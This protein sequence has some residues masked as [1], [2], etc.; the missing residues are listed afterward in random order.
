M[1]QFP[2][3]APLAPEQLQSKCDP[4]RIEALLA[5]STEKTTK[6]P[7]GQKRAFEALEFGLNIKAK[8]YNIFVAGSPG[9]G[10][11]STTLRQIKKRARRDPAP[12][13]LCYLFNF[14]DHYRPLAAQLAQGMGTILE[15][16]LQ[17]RV[18]ALARSI[19][20]V[21]NEDLFVKRTS[22]LST[23]LQQKKSEL[24]DA[25]SSIAEKYELRMELEDEQFLVVPLRDG[26]PIESDV[27]DNL[28]MEEQEDIQQRVSSF[29]DEAAPVMAEQ[30]IHEQRLE[31]TLSTMERDAIHNLV[32]NAIDAL[33]KE[34][35]DED[36]ALMTYFLGMQD[37]IMENYKELL[38]LGAEEEE[39]LDAASLEPPPLPLQ[40]QVNTLVSHKGKGA[41]VVVEKE[42]TIPHL[43]GYIEYQESPMGLATDHTLLRGGA[44]HRANGGYLVLQ[45][46][47]L[48]RSPEVWS[49]FKR[50]LRH[51]EV[52]IQDPHADPDKPRLYGAIRPLGL[53]L[54]LK[55]ILI[56]SSESYYQL[57]S[58]DEDFDRIFKVKAEF[59][60]WIPRSEDREL[61]YCLFLQ[62]ISEEEKLL[63]PDPS[64]M[65]RM[66]E[67]SSRDIESKHRLATSVSSSLDL[68]CEADYWARKAKHETIRA[69]DIEQALSARDERH[70][71]VE[72]N[73]VELIKRDEIL[74]DSEGFHVGQVNALLVYISHDFSFGLPNKIT[75]RTYVGEEGVINID[76][77][78]RL[79]GAIHDKGSMILI[80]LLGSLWGQQH[81]LHFNAS[82]TFEQLYGEVEGDSA[83]CAEFYALLSS[84]AQQ[85][86]NQGIAVTGS[87]NQLGLIQP[88]GE[89]N[90]KIEGM[91]KI[92]QQRGLTGNQGVIIPVQNVDHL[93]LKSEVIEAVKE[94]K[95]HIWPIRHIEEGVEILMNIPA[96]EQQ[97]DGSWPQDTLYGKVQQRL[98]ELYNRNKAKR[99]I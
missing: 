71:T 20:Q 86:L 84:L 70:K 37:Y 18:S 33:I 44:L 17:Q 10:K 9:S 52:R 2:K 50:T 23:Q 36:P 75:A 89:V 83:S 88:I 74:I 30:Q 14:D 6:G 57:M 40:Y 1:S 78:A 98:T 85:P 67:Q 65:A 97:E 25:I 76:R 91:F 54:N 99:L 46:N 94:G 82:I 15:K 34:F 79:S 93:M 63:A 58:Q 68:M 29:Q 5:K 60:N 77:E 43:F 95:F 55:V 92:C 32:D 47:D 64:A 73:I 90:A 49:T 26:E 21:L 16:R 53:K 22:S 39:E 96:G 87:I 35:E 4:A 81:P 3:I 61:E 7:V 66:I 38:Q 12:K 31:E 48:L 42:P 27:F 19:Y 59:E 51:R 24:F 72:R 69:E 41:P 56:G 28:S 8:G 62:R 80:G 11:T 45:A 13:D